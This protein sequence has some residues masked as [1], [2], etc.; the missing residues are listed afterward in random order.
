[1]ASAPS[2]TMYQNAVAGVLVLE[3][4]FDAVDGKEK[5]L[6]NRPAEEI[7][8]IVARLRERGAP[9]DAAAIHA[10]VEANPA[11]F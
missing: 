1:M 3:V 5:L 4:A 8:T 11:A 10:I 6:Q 9:G 7:R 2:T